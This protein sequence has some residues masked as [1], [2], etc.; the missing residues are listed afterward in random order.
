[1][2]ILTWG[3]LQTSSLL[4][5]HGLLSWPILSSHYNVVH[6]RGRGVIC[7]IHM[8]Q[9]CLMYSIPY[10]AQMRQIC[11][12][13]TITSTHEA[14]MPHVYHTK[15]TWGKYASCVPSQTHM[16]NICL[17]YVPN[18]HTVCASGVPNMTQV[19]CISVYAGPASLQGWRCV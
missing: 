12:M 9:I 15:L 2:S 7:C 17:T 1:M 11:L 5:R 3:C 10:Q 18:Q 8:R 6:N 16:R 4:N 14:N 13:Y 19:S